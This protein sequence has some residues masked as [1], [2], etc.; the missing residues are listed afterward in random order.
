MPEIWKRTAEKDKRFA[1]GDDYAGDA[2]LNTETSRVK[3][4]AVGHAPSHPM[5]DVSACKRCNDSGWLPEIEGRDGSYITSR[6]C[7]CD[8]GD[9]VS[10]LSI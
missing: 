2:W 10:C 9:R 4:V 8:A 3:Y 6:P 1:N 7:K 5:F